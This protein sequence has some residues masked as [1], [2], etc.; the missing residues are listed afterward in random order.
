MLAYLTA[1]SLLYVGLGVWLGLLYTRAR[2]ADSPATGQSPANGHS[3]KEPHTDAAVP[4]TV[5]APVS[6]V[7]TS[8]STELTLESE[9]NLL[10]PEDWFELLADSCPRCETFIEAGAQILGMRVGNYLRQLIE[11]E[12]G[13]RLQMQ[14]LAVPELDTSPDASL[15]QE[16]TPM[17]EAQPANADASLQRQKLLNDLLRQNRD[18]Q[19]H[20]K[21]VQAVLQRSEEDEAALK[22]LNADLERLVARQLSQLEA[23][24]KSCQLLGSVANSAYATL[25]LRQEV[26]R[27][28]VWAH[29][30]RDMLE[31]FIAAFFAREERFAVL[32]Q[33]Y[34]VDS[35]G[36]Y[37]RV[38]IEQ[39][40]QSW[41][42]DDSLRIRTLSCILINLDQ[43]G[44]LNEQVGVWGANQILSSIA[45]ILQGQMRKSRGNDALGRFAG[46][47]FMMFL[48]D[49]GPRGAT[50]AA[51][52][53]R[54]TVE[55]AS[56][57]LSDANVNLTV[58]IGV[59]DVRHDDNSESLLARLR[60]CLDAG[61]KLGPNQ[62][63][64]DEGTGPGTVQPPIYDVAALRHIID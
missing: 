23:T 44:Q 25:R 36:L 16:T 37:N 64:L 11:I 58:S 39:L 32:D 52:R 15:R 7:A 62:T 29:E 49:T 31:S 8:L 28:I 6:P 55:R 60:A 18:W 51:E 21:E 46:Q 41:W 17:A 20:Q 48:P 35:M 45:G 38:G 24:E 63:I 9:E 13:V 26:S 54:Q 30:F 50:S 61:K 14:K 33:K 27:C 43:C 3:P 57:E 19:R 1:T 40:L 4:P 10:A 22:V 12:A 5:E 47:L 53:L 59:T 2:G 56:F 42:R 34:L